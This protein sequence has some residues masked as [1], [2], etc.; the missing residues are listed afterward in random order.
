MKIITDERC[1][2]YHRAGHPERPQRISRT[3]EKL[4]GQTE[5]PIA[6]AEP[7][8]AVEQAREYCRG[9]I[10]KVSAGWPVELSTKL[11]EL[12]EP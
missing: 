8:P 10:A 9:E 3:L 7:L 6:W 2:G 4:R 12:V 5:V 1:T 11:K